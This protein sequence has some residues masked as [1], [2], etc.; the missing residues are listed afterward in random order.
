MHL[1]NSHTGLGSWKSKLTALE[2]LKE[3]ATTLRPPP[4]QTRVNW[5]PWHEVRI[6]K[7][8]KSY[9]NFII[10]K[11]RRDVSTARLH[12]YDDPASKWCPPMLTWP[13]PAQV[14]VV[15]LSD[16]GLTWRRYSS[17]SGSSGLE[18]CLVPDRCLVVLPAWPWPVNTS[19]SWFFT[20]LFS[21]YCCGSGLHS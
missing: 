9:F 19:C 5:E 4:Y 8:L 14:W 17:G 13:S 18:C 2:L 15:L 6:E 1:K 12:G 3:G 11:E 20:M 10:I 16:T 7:H 21:W